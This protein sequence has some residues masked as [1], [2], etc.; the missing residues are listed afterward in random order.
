MFS[1]STFM[2]FCVSIIP[3]KFITTVLVHFPKQNR[4]LTMHVLTY[5]VFRGSVFFLLSLSSNA[6]LP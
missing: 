4:W 2:K 3:P 6:A 5:T 1:N